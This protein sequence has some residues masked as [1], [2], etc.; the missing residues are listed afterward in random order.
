MSQTI[1]TRLTFILLLPVF[2]ILS[3]LCCLFPRSP[4]GVMR[5]FADLIVIVAV[6]ILSILA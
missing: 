4:R 5:L 1:E 6:A 2:C 3:A